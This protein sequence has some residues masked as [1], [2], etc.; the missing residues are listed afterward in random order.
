MGDGVAAAQRQHLVEIFQRLFVALERVKN[1]AVIRQHVR[2]ARLRLQRG[3]DQAERFRRLALLVAKHAAQMQRIEML[4]SAA[5]AARR[6]ARLDEAPLAVQG[7][8][9]LDATRR[10]QAVASGQVWSGWRQ[11]EGRRGKSHERDT[12]LRGSSLA[13]NLDI[14]PARSAKMVNQR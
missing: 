12:G 5:R 10:I 7:Q 1:D 14:D 2:R 9:L 3:G 8:R 4:G 6:A 11:P 13:V